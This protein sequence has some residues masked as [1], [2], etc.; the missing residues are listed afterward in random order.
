MTAVIPT[1]GPVKPVKYR[2]FKRLVLAD[3]ICSIPNH[4][5]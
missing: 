3:C 5:A 2:Q 1:A 4:P